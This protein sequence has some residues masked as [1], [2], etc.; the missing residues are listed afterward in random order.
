MNAIV[1]LES[2]YAPTLSKCDDVIKWILSLL[3]QG[4]TIAV[5]ASFGKD[6]LTVT[7]LFLEALRRAKETGIKMAP[8]HYVTHADTRIEN[9]INHLYAQDMIEKLRDF[10]VQADLPLE[11]HVVE[12]YLSN[13]FVVET[14]GRGKLPRFVD[15]EKRECAYDWKVQPSRRLLKKLVKAS[16]KKHPVCMLLGN[17]HDES[18]ARD[19][20]M[21][22]RGEGARV[23]LKDKKGHFTNS[24]IA[25]WDVN[26]VFSVL[27]LIAT[28]LWPKT[29]I[30][31]ASYC[32]SIYRDM[33]EGQCNIIIGNQQ[34]R[35]SCGARG[36]CWGCTV[37]GEKDK[38]AESMVN[39]DPVG[40]ESLAPLL[41]FRQ[42]LIANRFNFEARDWFGR[43]VENGFVGIRPDNYSSA[44]K[45]RML[46]WLITMDVE[47][48]SRAAIWQE[49]ID[50][51]EVPDNDYY[52]RLA[53]PAFQIVTPKQLLA[54]DF[55]WSI[56]R[57]SAESFPALK[58]WHEIRVLGRRYHI[59]DDNLVAHAR[60]PVPA[61]RWFYVDDFKS[62]YKIDGLRDIVG[63]A[64]NG[65]RRPG[66]PVAMTVN[67]DG[68]QESVVYHETVKNLDVDETE[69]GCFVYLE[70]ESLYMKSAAYDALD[71]AKYLLDRGLVK[72]GK[73][74]AAR[75]HKMARRAGYWDH[76]QQ[77]LNMT[78]DELQQHARENSISSGQYKR[79]LASH[80]QFSTLMGFSPIEDDQPN[81][82][83]A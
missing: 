27:S 58:I 82:Q 65:I 15:S 50:S 47:E 34:N 67:I 25:D 61:K 35:K 54:I 57:D 4:Y 78:Y 1:D 72:L 17:R 71:G 19:E 14:I 26:D 31:D 83:A 42:Y 63:E 73:G 36:G 38:S 59:S 9:P 32:L 48:E 11:V 76:K 46:Q 33:N 77:E 74:K 6:S 70:F 20:N 80:K 62:K 41:R 16:G 10:A 7:L 51:G 49:K 28:P 75:Y 45:R 40:Y 52:R 39:S 2:I 69:A 30:A 44:E 68:E 22:T 64:I 79:M 5:P 23:L 60:K 8:C 56:H 55:M 53:E 24:P 29:F 66:K 81:E 18:D 21:K 13:H 43:S 3:E 12:P 37:S